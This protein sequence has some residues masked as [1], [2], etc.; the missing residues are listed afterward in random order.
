[1]HD[2]TDAMAFDGSDPRF[3]DLGAFPEQARIFS[4]AAILARRCRFATLGV[5][6]LLHELLGED[7]FRMMIKYGGGDP[8]T[9]RGIL[10]RAFRDHAELQRKRPE[11]FELTPLVARLASGSAAFLS[12]NPK[13]DKLAV[14]SDF[15][16][17]VIASLDAS[18]IAEGAINDCGAGA[19]LFDAEIEVDDAEVFERSLERVANPQRVDRDGIE[20]FNDLFDD[21]AFFDDT[22]EQGLAGVF[23][24]KN[25]KPEPAAEEARKPTPKAEPAPQVETPRATAKPAARAGSNGEDV[26]SAVNAALRDIGLAASQGEID[27]V[28]GRERE[29][30]SVLSILRRRRKSSVILYGEAGVGKTAIAEGLAL[31]LRQPGV[32]A[33]LAQ[34]PFY[35]LALRDL[36][37]GTKYRGEFEDRMRALLKRLTEERA[38]V[39]IDEFHGIVG[40]GASMGSPGLDGANM[41]KS[42]LGR[43]KITVI[44]A[45]TPQEMRELR[46]DGAF[47]RRFD[48]LNIREPSARET[49]HILEGAAWGYLEHH[50]LGDAPGV[51]EEIVRVADLYQPERRFPDKAFDLLD[52]ACVVA[53]ETA[54]DRRDLASML[55]DVGHVH[56]AA[57]HLGLRM[58]RK[59]S[60]SEALRLS[61]MRDDLSKLCQ[62]QEEAC[63]LI[64][65]ELRA[66]AL[67]LGQA[68]VAGSIL[69]AGAEGSGHAALA[70]GSAEIMG[71]PH[72]H[73]DL[74][75]IREQSG[76]GGLVGFAG[77]PGQ[78]QGGMLVDIA[79]QHR[80]VVVHL[81]NIQDATPD[82]QELLADICRKGVFRAADGRTLS[83]RHAVLIMSLRVDL[84]GAGM[85]AGFATAGAAEASPALQHE[86][87]RLIEPLRAE[88]S[89]RCTLEPTETTA[90]REFVSKRIERL[91][92]T[93]AEI[94]VTFDIG[95]AA[96]ERLVSCDDLAVVDAELRKLRDQ[97]LKAS[98]DEISEMRDGAFSDDLDYA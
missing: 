47:M 86:R 65:E 97:A 32:E 74:G 52:A 36:V 64:S 70:K 87:R 1:M 13:A 45:T 10:A 11:G 9:C 22:R 17:R 54:G 37:A 8:D 82:I 80:G 55:L 14:A 38:I 43:G 23:A 42:E 2:M 44:G 46:K 51:L 72:A 31:K 60:P 83:L 78:E 58:P 30:G 21:Q 67:N 77:L 33:S 90:M 96:L 19:L 6:H 59:P 12:K 15:F 39:F 98:L 25:A 5:E 16:A 89:T 94:G 29:I 84:D 34:R 50:G 3:P 40:A 91:S 57:E 56:V 75:R 79:D 7:G 49:L 66:A 61:S 88:I 63:E 18:A 68:G 48:T 95:S 62:G 4:S 53:V 41:I 71:L 92:S 81:D 85:S 35:E 93:L 76:I 26:T 27:P 73:I 20:A 24:R 69:I 28:V